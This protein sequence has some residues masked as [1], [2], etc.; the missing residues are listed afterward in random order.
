MDYEDSW[1][2][3]ENTVYAALV[4]ASSANPKGKKQNAFIGY[5][6][7]GGYNMWALI[8][9][10]GGSAAH[11]WNT[12]AARCWMDATIEGIYATR[13]TAQQISLKLISA[14]PIKHSQNVEI[15]RMKSNG[16]PSITPVPDDAGHLFWQLKIDCEIV[17]ATTATFSS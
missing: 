6:P 12:R 7:A 15:F 8:I 5:L 14:M 17:F 16:M 10:G 1:T 3:A 13:A 4:A 2:L 9:G 11:T